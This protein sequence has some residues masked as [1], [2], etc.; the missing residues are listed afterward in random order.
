MLT[1]GSGM[2]E[3]LATLVADKWFLPGVKSPMLGKVMLVFEGLPTDLAG[4]GSGTCV[5]KLGINHCYYL[6]IVN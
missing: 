2:G 1:V 3:A 5:E 4:K 6:D